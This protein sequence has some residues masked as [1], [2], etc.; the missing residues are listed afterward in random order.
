MGLFQKVMT[1][2]LCQIANI[3][4]GGTTIQ[5]SILHDYCTVEHFVNIF[6]T[7]GTGHVCQFRD[8]KRV[9]M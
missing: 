1:H 4:N 8:A 3:E 5:V 2:R 7:K 6:T 9:V